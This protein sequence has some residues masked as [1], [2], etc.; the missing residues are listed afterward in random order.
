MNGLTWIKA[1]ASDSNGSCVLVAKKPDGGRLVRDSKQGDT[2]YIL[3]FT[4]AEWD[5]FLD[6]ARSGE[7]D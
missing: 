1:K 5:A 4:Q 7:F 3:S 2:G 6:G